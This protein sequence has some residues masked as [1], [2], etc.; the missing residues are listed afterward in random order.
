MRPLL[1]VL[2]LSASFALGQNNS[3][4]TTPDRSKHDR[5]QVTVQGC[6]SRSNGD[7]VLIKQNPAVTYQLQTTHKIRLHNYLGQRV[8]ITGEKGP[9]LSTSS[10]AMNKV[11][12]ASPVTITINS[13]KTIENQCPLR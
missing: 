7:Y 12:S 5:D 11:G 9:T 1:L 8:E 10:D 3:T 4:A 13:I 6:V 2:L